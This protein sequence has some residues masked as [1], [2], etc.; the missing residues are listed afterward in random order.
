LI[1]SAINPLVPGST[2]RKSDWGKC[3]AEPTVNTGCSF[4]DSVNNKTALTN[5]SEGTFGVASTLE[6]RSNAIS[7]TR[8]Y[9]RVA[10]TFE[11]RL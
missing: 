5:L 2:T 7:N 4:S 1:T 11:I 8:S 9:L 10:V 6:P 3:R